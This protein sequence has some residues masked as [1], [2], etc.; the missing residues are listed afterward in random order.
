MPA[1]DVGYVYQPWSILLNI[2]YRD[3]ISPFFPQVFLDS[4]QHVLRELRDFLKASVSPSSIPPHEN[5]DSD[6]SERKRSSDVGTPHHGVNID[7]N[8]VE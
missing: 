2:F 7:I 4:E 1:A 5:D 6:T 3:D 8:R